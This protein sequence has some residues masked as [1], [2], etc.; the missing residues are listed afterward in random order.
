MQI[1]FLGAADAVTGSRHLIDTG[2]SRILLDCGLFQG[3][4]QLRERN[5]APLPVPAREIDAVVLSHAHLDHSGYLPALVRQ[6]FRGHVHATPATCDLAELLLLDSAHIQEE[7]ARHANAH[8][9]SKHRPARPLYTVEDARRALQRFRPRA[10]HQPLAL[11]ERTT[12]EF[13]PAG[14]LLGAASVRLTVGERTLVFS[15]DL[16]RQGD[17]LM[18][19]PERIGQADVLLVESTYGD[20]LHPDDDPMQQLAAIITGTLDHGGSV[21]LPTFA[22]ARAQA[23]M[24]ALHRLKQAGRI[25]R[26]VPVYLD[27]PMAAEATRVYAGH[28]DL[29]RVSPDEVQAMCEGVTM[30]TAPEASEE[31][32]RSHYPRIILSSSGMATGGRVLHHLK[33][34]APHAKHHIVFPGFQ[35]PGSR[36]A[37]L[38]GGAR[39]VKI[40]GSYVPVRARVSHLEGFSGHADADEL[41]QWL[42]SF[43]RPPRHTFVVHGEPQA[44]DALRRRI[45]EELGWPHVHVPEH[46]STVRV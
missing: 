13:I 35:V 11:D 7:D 33:A 21:L 37:A 22:V 28:Q 38:V 32:T 24:L 42:R 3:Y 18:A 23:L 46:R 17:L 41:M 26:Q 31:L 30:V 16:G 27:S 43:G 10:F 15:G 8:G 36:G 5:W 45:Q 14:H 1:T 6:G 40:H 2:S 12:L 25:P 34:M 20:R 39:E 4:K 9:Y 29:L 19:P 44:A